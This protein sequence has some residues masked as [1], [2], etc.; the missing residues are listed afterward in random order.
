ANHEP[1]ILVAAR[2]GLVA[3]EL[4]ALGWAAHRVISALRARTRGSSSDAA[5][6]VEAVVRDAFGQGLFRC[7]FR[8]RHRVFAFSKVLTSERA[9]KCPRG[10]GRSPIAMEVWARILLQELSVVV[11]AFGW[12]RGAIP[13]NARAFVVTGAP[14]VNFAVGF[15]IAIET[16]AVHLVV[17]PSRPE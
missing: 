15:L 1:S 4:G 9:A 13:P 7:S 8:G 2:L 14:A 11:H 17:S 10:L 3:L 6:V 5:D 16:L 12:F